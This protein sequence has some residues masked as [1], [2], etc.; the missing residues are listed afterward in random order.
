MYDRP[1]L[2][3]ELDAFQAD[4]LQDAPVWSVWRDVRPVEAHEPDRSRATWRDV[5]EIIAGTVVLGLCFLAIVAALFVVTG[6]AA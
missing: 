6:A 5:W 4:S 2:D 1:L 3:H